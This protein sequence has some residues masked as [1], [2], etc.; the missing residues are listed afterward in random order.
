MKKILFLWVT[1]LITSVLS[2]A[3]TDTSSAV[4]MD[5]K[6]AGYY[7]KAVEAMKAEKYEDAIALLDSGST[8][9]KDYRL[10]Y[11]KAQAYNKLGKIEDA[12]KTFDETVALN[13]K[14]DMAYIA[15]GNTE[16]AAKQYDEAIADFKKASEVSTNPDVKKNAEESIK[17]ATD[18][19]AIDYY[20]QGTDAY[21]NEKYDVAVQNFDKAIAI[22]PDYKFYYQKGLAL[23]KLEKPAEAEASFKQA[24]AANDTFD[25]AYIAL[26]GLQIASKKYEEADKYYA[27]ALKINSSAALKESIS[28][29]YYAI[30]NST[31]RDKKYDLSVNYMKKSLELAPSDIAFLG[32]AKAQI[33]KKQYND[34]IASLDSAAQ[35]K[36]MVTDGALAYYK[37]VIYLNKGEDAK[38]NE[39]FSAALTDAQFKKAAQSQ[40]DYIKAKKAGAK[41][42]K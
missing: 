22:S 7:N 17:F 30:G 6:A 21:K 19:K 31:Y 28:K 8:L 13:P 16:I 33:E 34:A 35:N 12:K 5:P 10:S 9:Q 25:L 23:S 18:T 4:T 42:K 15:K 1:I 24:V 20:N 27:E 40:I 32:L 38:A 11:L 36:K 29:G 26:G 41:P 37:G 39:Q 14:Y 3:Q 2:S